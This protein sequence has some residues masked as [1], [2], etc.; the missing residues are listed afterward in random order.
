MEKKWGGGGAKTWILAAGPRQG[1]EE[2]SLY[3]STLL[4]VNSRKAN[5]YI[6]LLRLWFQWRV[7]KKVVS[8]YL[9]DPSNRI[10]LKQEKTICESRGK[11]LSFLLLGNSKPRNFE[12]DKKRMKWIL[13][14]WFLIC[15]LWRWRSGWIVW[16]SI[17]LLPLILPYQQRICFAAMDFQLLILKKLYIRI[18]VLN[19]L[20]CCWNPML[21][22]LVVRG[23]TP[24][25]A[26]CMPYGYLT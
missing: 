3:S 16:W 21:K 5:R 9:L 25:M 22:T 1:E 15:G 26:L 8:S 7:K 11:H 6:F 18:P 14:S 12:R 17:G 13:N 20:F 19:K 2:T 10:K 24:G 23:H 4:S